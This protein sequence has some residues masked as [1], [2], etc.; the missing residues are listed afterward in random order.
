MLKVC[1]ILMVLLGA[2]VLRGSE[3]DVAL[4]LNSTGKIAFT[5][6]IYQFEY[7]EKGNI[8][9]VCYSMD[10]KQFER[11]KNKSDKIRFYY[12]L[13]MYD[14]NNQ[15]I[16]SIHESKAP[17]IDVSD[18]LKKALFVDMNKFIISVDSLMLSITITDSLTGNKGNIKTIVKRRPFGSGLSLSCPV[19]ITSLYKTTPSDILY[20]G[21]IGVVPNTSRVYYTSAEY[22]KK[23]FFYFE[24]NN[25]QY[26]DKKESACKLSYSIRN[27][28]G[29][30]VKS[31]VLHGL[32]AEDRDISRI[33]KIEIDSLASGIYKLVIIATDLTN[34]QSCEMSRYFYI[35]STD[36]QDDNALVLPMS[37]DD[38]RNYYDQIKYIATDKELRI[39]EM[40]DPRGKQQFLLDFWKRRDLTPNTPQ[41]EFMI[42]HFRLI[43]YCKDNFR[44]GVNGDMGRVYI[45]YGPPVNIER[46]ASY[47]GNSKAV[48]IWEYNIQGRVQFVFVDRTNDGN[49]VLM[50]ST[51]SDEIN[52]RNWVNELR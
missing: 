42:E 37:D 13:N 26:N 5:A 11:N 1:Q 4:P 28:T 22:K 15:S 34:E 19:F 51:H 49:Y 27:I 7:A 25:L 23:L 40:L 24:I 29:Q 21:G 3:I 35:Y 9:E 18:S 38:I 41:N 43:A 14:F 50:H 44:K 39:Y 33:G 31:K 12:D 20:R 32:K 36:M 30:E 48:E 17:E 6:D 2:F 52:N 16:A 45:M 47:M 8:L 10:I 46:H